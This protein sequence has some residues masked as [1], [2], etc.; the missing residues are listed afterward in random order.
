MSEK[1][2]INKDVKHVPVKNATDLQ[3]LRLEKLMANPVNIKIK[4]LL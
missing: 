4:N 1:E 2:K 3:R